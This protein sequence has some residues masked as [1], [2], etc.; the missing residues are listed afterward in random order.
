[1]PQ[2]PSR[3]KMA[4]VCGCFLVLLSLSYYFGWLSAKPDAEP[5]AYFWQRLPSLGSAA[6]GSDNLSDYW[7]ARSKLLTADQ[8]LETGGNVVLHGAERQVNDLLTA[9]KREEYEMTPF[10]AGRHFMNAR[11]DIRRSKV[12]Q[13]IRMMPKGT[14][15]ARGG[16]ALYLR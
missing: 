5:V 1:M 12:F 11:E 14:R 15:T 8:L 10:A 6:G 7:T 9:F 16:D 13:L 4:L 2:D 3:G